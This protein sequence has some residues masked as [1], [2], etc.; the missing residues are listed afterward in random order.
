[1]CF[2][3]VRILCE[4]R[5]CVMREARTRR[6]IAQEKKCQVDAQITNNVVCNKRAGYDDNELATAS[7][8]TRVMSAVFT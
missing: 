1:M 7:L 4:S 5:I 8:I 3:G 2:A 6:S